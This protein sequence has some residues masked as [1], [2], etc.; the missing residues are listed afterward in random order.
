MADTSA[1]LGTWK[2]VS[3][4]RES[5][6]TGERADALG[7]DPLGFIN[8]GANGR[9]FAIV[10]QKDRDPPAGP[11]PTNGKF[12]SGRLARSAA[13]GAG[14][15]L[16]RCLE[17]TG[18]EPGLAPARELLGRHIARAEGSRRERPAEP[19]HPSAEVLAE[20]PANRDLSTEAV[21]VL[22]LAG[23]DA[24]ADPGV[25]DERGLL[26]TAVAL[27]S[28][29]GALLPGLRGID[30][31]QPDALAVDLNRITVDH[32]GAAG[33]QLSGRRDSRRSDKKGECKAPNYVTD[34]VPIWP[35]T[36]RSNQSAPFV[37]RGG[38]CLSPG[39][40]RRAQGPCRCREA[41]TAS[42]TFSSAPS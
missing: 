13:L 5:V 23:H 40:T 16:P 8:Y 1:L 38:P 11:V 12:P 9:M 41:R 32:R 10:I 27:A 19:H 20:H 26:T 36:S 4:Q 35:R 21:L 3:W 25:Q 17:A 28:S 37:E 42:H 31:E 33:E 14:A 6:A 2:M 18:P 7:P 24:I 22:R 34:L 15:P 30:A 39:T 29:V